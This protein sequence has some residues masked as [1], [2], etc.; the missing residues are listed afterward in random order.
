ML[1]GHSLPNVKRHSEDPYQCRNAVGPLPC[2]GDPGRIS[3]RP[4]TKEVSYEQGYNSSR[5]KQALVATIYFAKKNHAQVLIWFRKAADQ[6]SAFGQYNLGM[7]CKDG[8]GVTKRMIQ[9]ARR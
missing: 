9:Y 2:R 7:L 4:L 3:L 5:T 8:L 6:G 1:A